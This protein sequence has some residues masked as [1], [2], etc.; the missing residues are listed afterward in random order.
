MTIQSPVTNSIPVR[1]ARPNPLGGN[2]RIRRTSLRFA[3]N[4]KT[5]RSVSSFELSLMTRISNEIRSESNRAISSAKQIPMFSCSLWAGITTESF[6][7]KNCD[8]KGD[9]VISETIHRKI[10][11]HYTVR[12]RVLH[13]RQTYIGCWRTELCYRPIVG[14]RVCRLASRPAVE[15]AGPRFF[16][17]PSRYEGRLSNQ[18]PGRD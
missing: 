11:P 12:R 18:V 5:S 9:D 17:L 4:K 6:T 3:D 15:A 1:I 10:R 2:R 16:K 8:K 14:Q 13:F 7:V